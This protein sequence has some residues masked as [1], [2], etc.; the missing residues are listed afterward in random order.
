MGL[1]HA[2]SVS[3]DLSSILRRRRPEN[4]PVTTEAEYLKEKQG[5]MEFL[6]EQLEETLKDRIRMESVQ[7]KEH[8]MLV[9]CRQ[10][11]TLTYLGFV[12]LPL[13]FITV[14][15]SFFSILTARANRSGHA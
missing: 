4:T 7:M 8:R 3:K 5:D 15:S 13:F 11:S 12:F 10:I 9:Q 2:Y 1:N 6:I 14:S